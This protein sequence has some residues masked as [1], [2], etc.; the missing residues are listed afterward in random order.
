MLLS[1]W[2]NK[3]LHFNILSSWFL[4]NTIRMIQPPTRNTSNS[5]CT[6][7]NL[8]NFLLLMPTPLLWQSQSPLLNYQFYYMWPF[9]LWNTSTLGK[10]WNFWLGKMQHSFWLEHT[11]LSLSRSHGHVICSFNMFSSFDGISKDQWG[12]YI[13]WVHLARHGTTAEPV[14]LMLVLYPGQPPVIFSLPFFRSFPL[15]QNVVAC[16]DRQKRVD[17]WHWP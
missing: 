13:P 11:L 2:R 12:P 3:C 16:Q 9:P 10:K 5:K 7:R 8:Q 1:L 4:L 15:P 6:H 14:Y 17:E